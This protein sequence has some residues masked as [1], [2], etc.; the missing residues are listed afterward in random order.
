MSISRWV[1]PW[2]KSTV[3][4]T[5][6]VSVGMQRQSGDIEEKVISSQSILPG[7]IWDRELHICVLLAICAVLEWECASRIGSAGVFVGS[8]ATVI[9]HSMSKVW[10]Q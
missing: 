6:L 1:L 3:L 9:L 10:L 4:C 7:V 8:Y 2:C 5:I